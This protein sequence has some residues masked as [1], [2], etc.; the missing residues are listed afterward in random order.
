MIFQSEAGR[1]MRGLFMEA[2]HFR[3]GQELLSDQDRV[4][5]NLVKGFM[6]S[7]GVGLEMVQVAIPEE[8]SVDDVNVI[9][10]ILN[11]KE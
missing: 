10:A 5:Q 8:E 4:E 9:D 11:A 6:A 2:G 3:V 1:L 7:C